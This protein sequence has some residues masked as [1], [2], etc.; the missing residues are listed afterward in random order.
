MA[1]TSGQA[2]ESGAAS[3]G[4][5]SFGFGGG[6]G[7]CAAAAPL[8]TPVQW[9]PQAAAAAPSFSGASRYR[10]RPDE[11]DDDD[12]DD[13]EQGGS[14]YARG[15]RARSSATRKVAPEV[16][17]WRLM[18]AQRSHVH[19]GHI[20][21]AVPQEAVAEAQAEAEQQMLAMA[22]QAHGQTRLTQFFA[23]QP[24]AAGGAQAG[25][26]AGDAMVE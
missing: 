12:D 4:T 14:R 5:S 9:T 6:T 22:A 17:M 23:A 24:G 16:T 1:E 7:A 25:V 11:D 8:S 2:L 15:R 19:A 21:D 3:A 18:N 10:R 26:E 20:A 13:D